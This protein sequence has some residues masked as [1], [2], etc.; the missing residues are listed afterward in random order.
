MPLLNQVYIHIVYIYASFIFVYFIVFTPPTLSTL[1]IGRF[2]VHHMN[3]QSY[4]CYQ[5]SSSHFC[6][7]VVSL[8]FVV[9]C[10]HGNYDTSVLL[11]TTEERV[12]YLW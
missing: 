1:T 2:I 4:L 8:S 12:F 11:V 3:P 7:L 10:M 6:G 9:V 5:Y